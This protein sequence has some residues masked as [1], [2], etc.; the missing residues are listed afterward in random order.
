MG[1]RKLY[2]IRISDKKNPKNDFEKFE[3]DLVLNNEA[4]WDKDSRNK[5]KPGSD[6]LAFIIGPNGHEI[7]KFFKVI[8]EIERENHWVTDSPYVRGNG[9]NSVGHRE[10]IMLKVHPKIESIEWKKFKKD[11]NFAPNNLSWMPRG[12]QVVKNTHL[13]PFQI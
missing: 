7:V 9:T 6:T 13:L 3:K 1:N 12:M 10:G 4:P 8:S 11:I 2:M 5:I